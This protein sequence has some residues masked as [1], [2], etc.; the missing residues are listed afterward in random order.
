[1]HGK[2]HLYVRGKRTILRPGPVPK[3]FRHC[4]R[5]SLR[6][7]RCTGRR[8]RIVPTG[9]DA[10]AVRLFGVQAWTGTGHP[11]ADFGWAITTFMAVGAFSALAMR[12]ALSWHFGREPKE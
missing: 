6:L 9:S 1:M 11:R 2:G 4:G 5:H 7:R 3:P 10:Y 8:V 12:W